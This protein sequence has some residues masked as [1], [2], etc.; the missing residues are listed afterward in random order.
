MQER[1][2]KKK[3][4]FSFYLFLYFDFGKIIRENSLGGVYGKDRI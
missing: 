1:K 2:D 4:M 3:I